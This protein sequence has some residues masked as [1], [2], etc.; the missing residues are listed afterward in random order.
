MP[1]SRFAGSYGNFYFP[2]FKEAPYRLCQFTFPPTALEESFFLRPLQ[3]LLFVNFLMMAIL[4]GVRWYLI[5]VLICV[6][7]IISDVEHLVCCCFSSLFLCFWLCW[8]CITVCG[9][10]ALCVEHGGCFVVALAAYCSGF[11]YCPALAL[12]HTS[13]SSCGT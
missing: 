13:F 7:L 12:W 1:R 8:V 4:T 5:V 10:S 6:S 11:S 3:H 9:L 2:F